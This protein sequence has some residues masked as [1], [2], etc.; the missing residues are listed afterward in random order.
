M[1]NNHIFI[2]VAP[3]ETLKSIRSRGFKTFSPY[4]DES[5]DNEKNSYKR[6]KKIIIEV[7]RLCKLNDEQIKEFIL[8]TEEIVKYNYDKLI[9]DYSS[10]DLTF[11]VIK[12]ICGMTIKELPEEEL[13]EIVK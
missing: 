2:A 1:A 4:I 9:N 10:I 7:E 13:K 8:Q 5:Y 11:K 12:R 6:L 3:Y